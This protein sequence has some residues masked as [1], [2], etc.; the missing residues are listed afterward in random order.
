MKRAHDDDQVELAGALTSLRSEAPHINELGANGATTSK[1]DRF[2]GPPVEKRHAT[3]AAWAKHLDDYCHSNGVRIGIEFTDSVQKRN[4]EMRN[5]KRAKD[6]KFVRYLPEE[7]EAYRRSY[8]CHLGRKG[9]TRDV[10]FRRTACPFKLVAK[11]VFD[12]GNWEVEVT[13]S[14]A[15]HIHSETT[16]GEATTLASGSKEPESLL[17]PVFPIEGLKGSPPS[18][19]VLMDMA[20]RCK[21]M[22]ENEAMC[23]RLL[24]RLNDLHDSVAPIDEKDLRKQVYTDVVIRF[25]KLMRRKQLLL[26]LASSETVVFKIHEL[27]E[28][29]NG[30]ARGFEVS[31]TEELDQLRDDRAEQY[32]KLQLLVSSASD[33]MLINEFRGDQKLHEALMTLT[34][35]M[36]W[37]NQSPEM[38]ALLALKRDTFAR[39]TKILPG[40][41]TAE[42]FIPVD[43][44]EYEERVIGAGTFGEARRA[45]WLHYG[46]RREVIV[47]HLFKEIEHYSADMFLK[48]LEFW[49]TIEDQHIL[50]LLGGSHVDR[51]QFYVC[52]YASGGNLRDFFGQRENRTRL[53][54]MFRQAARGLLALHTAKLPHGALKCSNILVG[55]NNTVKLTDFGFRPVRS[56]S[57]SLSADADEA[58]A[59]AVR[60]KPKELLEETHDQEQQ[61]R[62]DIYALG[63]CMIEALTQQDP[64]AKVDNNQLVEVIRKGT[65]H[66]RPDAIL[67]AEWVF[68]CRLC[69]PDDTQRPKLVE[70]LKEIGVFAEE[71]QQRD[72]LLQM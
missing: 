51:P 41:P 5:S 28:K 32:A 68:I 2:T 52:E 71:E 70:V 67:D 53:W 31:S 1:E 11:S 21:R 23:T 12:G 63:M 54:R 62:A 55:A 47:K 25:V 24:Q 50:K 40:L 9:R 43:D 56:L 37:K 46:E 42:W 17:K 58:T 29:L 22:P 4:D 35:G 18:R 34:S 3:W 14:N 15:E 59:I 20:P 26:R 60:W 44:L 57:A 64:F 13:C 45:T 49:Y 27:H 19:K 39:V 38:L 66:D 10:K 69:N 8:V 61:Y 65:T 36:R 7:L 30:L 72:D 48:Q 16:G 33:R 6:G